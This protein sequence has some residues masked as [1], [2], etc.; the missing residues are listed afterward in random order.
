[1]YMTDHIFFVLPIKH[2]LNQDGEP[3]TPHKITTGTNPSIS[4][5][6]FL[7]FPYVVRKSTSHVDTK[8]LNI[9]HQS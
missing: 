3:T 5:L 9:R 6:S 8:E 7:F 2:L 4:N 1:M